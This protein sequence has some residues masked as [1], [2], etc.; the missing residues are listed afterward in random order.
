MPE[1]LTESQ[2]STGKCTGSYQVI[3]VIGLEMSESG[4]ALMLE[5]RVAPSSRPYLSE[6]RSRA[7]HHVGLTLERGLDAIMGF[8]SRLLHAEAWCWRG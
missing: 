1:T 2:T 3:K 6:A 4:W 8:L 5:G 7:A